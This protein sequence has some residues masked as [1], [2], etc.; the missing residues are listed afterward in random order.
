MV[1]KMYFSWKTICRSLIL[2]QILGFPMFGQAQN[3]DEDMLFDDMPSVFTAS[4]YEQ[5]ISEAPARISVITA[6]EIQRYGYRNLTE[7]LNSLPGIQLTDD[8]TYNYLG[9]RGLNVPGDF[10]S[11]IL[12]LVD[13]HRMNENIFDGVLIDQGGIVNVDMIKQIEMIRG[14]ASSLYGS[15]AFLGVINII[16]K[17]GRDIDGVQVSADTG[18]QNTHQGRISYGQNF[19]NGFEVLV[20]A[21]R[22]SS[23]GEDRYYAEFDD[24]ATNNGIAEDADSSHND[25]VL[26][27]FNYS[28]FRLS[29]AY[30]EYEKRIP[31][32]SY[33]TVF[34]DNRTHIPLKEVHT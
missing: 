3:E 29:V 19:D 31:N 6:K 26:A 8:E 4:K 34:N 14:P 21:S 32:A 18:S 1:F 30:A 2:I 5:K 24:P 12:V 13:G 20:S 7:A 15:S 16:T 11:R 33:E 23:K 22:Y 9:V 10:N 17:D 27:K 25:S 28:D